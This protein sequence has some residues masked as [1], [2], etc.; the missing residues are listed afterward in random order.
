MKVRELMVKDVVTASAAVASAQDAARTMNQKG[1]G[2]LVAVDA[3]HVVGI[4]TE[5]DLLRRIVEVCRNP[6]LTKM[7]EIMTRQVIVGDP[8]MELLEATR[9]MFEKRIKKLPIVERDRLVGLITLTDIA[10][11][12]SVDEKTINLIE[13]LQN[14]H[15][16]G[17][18]SYRISMDS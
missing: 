6:K 2:C 17:E 8:D 9:L 4:L 15:R 16:I 11:A 10:R 12:T 1:I 13:A 14:M 18:S 5:R 3:N 7:S